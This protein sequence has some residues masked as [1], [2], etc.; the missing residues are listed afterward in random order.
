MGLRA[1]WE[2]L[3]SPKVLLFRHVVMWWGKEGRQPREALARSGTTY[4]QAKS[5]GASLAPFGVLLPGC[6]VAGE[7][8][9][10]AGG[11]NKAGQEVQQRRERQVLHGGLRRASRAGGEAKE[12]IWRTQGEL[13]WSG[14]AG[15]KIKL[16]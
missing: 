1:I 10:G 6:G 4:K 2:T 11:I 13:G 3:Y 15:W 14:S 12:N 5:V 9:A 7:A 8:D 16:F